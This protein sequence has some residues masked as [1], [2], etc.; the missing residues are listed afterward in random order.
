MKI[1]IILASDEKN[2]IGK[3]GALAWNISTDMKYFKKITSETEDL[4]KLNAVV[5]GRNTWKSIPKKYRPLPERV[6]CILT[7]SI[8]TNDTDAKIDDF[9]LYFNSL[10]ICLSELQKK[11][12]IENIFIIGGASLYNQMLKEGKIEKIY[13]TKINGNYDCDVFFDG[14]PDDFSVESYTET[15]KEWEYEFSFW[16]YRKK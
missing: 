1:H 8:E 6:N 5:M 15:Q 13:L 4:A 3:N 9:V 7:R 2:G 14:V 10:E 12:N 11:E 16:V